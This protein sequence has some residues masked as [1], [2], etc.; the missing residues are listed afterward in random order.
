MEHFPKVNV[1]LGEKMQRKILTWDLLKKYFQWLKSSY[2]KYP[3][4]CICLNKFFLKKL[5]FLVSS[6]ESTW[7][8]YPFFFFCASDWANYKM[9]ELILVLDCVSK[10]PPQ[11]RPHGWSSIRDLYFKNP[12]RNSPGNKVNS[13]NLLV[14][15]PAETCFQTKLL[16]RK[17]SLLSLFFQSFGQVGFGALKEF[18]KRIWWWWWH[19]NTLLSVS[20]FTQ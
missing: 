5:L 20:F 17:Q 4:D 11:T 16:Y 9:V 13:F 15:A 1:L 8:L 14:S 2:C 7:K 10:T 19:S 12:C 6:V 18:W 3:E